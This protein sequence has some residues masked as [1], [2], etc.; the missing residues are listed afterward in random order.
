VKKLFVSLFAFI[1]TLSLFACSN[2]KVNIETNFNE[3]HILS[4]SVYKLGK[5]GKEQV[6]NVQRT[7]QNESL[8][9]SLEESLG[10]RKS[11]DPKA[12]AMLA[13]D[14]LYFEF[15][16]RKQKTTDISKVWVSKDK[17]TI[18]QG[19][20]YTKIEAKDTEGFHTFLSGLKLE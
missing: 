12:D 7:K 10:H 4:I 16:I 13:P 19:E 3:Q 8:F 6:A 9:L 20:N 5:N 18:E 14:T 15:K 1:F 17:I 2:N 11:A